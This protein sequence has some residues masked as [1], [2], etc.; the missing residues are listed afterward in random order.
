MAWRRLEILRADQ[1][2]TLALQ[3]SRLNTLFDLSR[4]LGM[5][6]PDG[7]RDILRH[8]ANILAGEFMIQRLLVLDLHGAVQVCRGLGV[9]PDSLGE[10]SLQ[11]L[12]G[13][14]TLLNLA[15]MKDQDHGHGFVYFA[16][17][18][19]GPLNDDDYMF[20]QT[21]LNITS[22]HLSALDLRE[23]RIQ[24]MKLEKD[25]ELARNI[26]R[27]ILPQRLPEP[28]GWQCAAAS[29]PYQAVGGDLYDLWI[30][31]DTDKGERL[32]MLVGDISGKGLPASLMM[33][34]LSAFLR[35]VAYKRVKNWGRMAQRLNARMNEVRDRNRYATLFAASLNQD[36]G[37]LRYVNC[38]HNPP[39]L[40]SGDGT[41]IRR[42]KATGPVVGLIADA[43]FR[44]GHEV[45]APG[46]VLIAF[47]DGIVEAE[48]SSGLEFG[49][50]SV[51]AEALASIEFAADDIFE[52]ILVA[53][54]SH[55]EETELRD[56]ATLLVIK[57][58]V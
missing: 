36:N 49:D 18:A 29:L 54:F 51:I 13:A 37:N 7:K 21:L 43:E 14:K 5:E 9:I 17:P 4:R 10:D 31:R 22:S 25:M 41:P 26:Q 20:L 55:I 47:T 15:E 40:I 45:M 48:N 56:D 12:I 2:R 6:E 8:F 1:N 32:H 38:G 58:C 42:L 16:D 52:Q 53:T 57:R 28:K 35:A 11:D 19:K 27:R 46:D 23:S 24:A 3:I 34:Q 44:E 33:T 50:D 30:A 39:I